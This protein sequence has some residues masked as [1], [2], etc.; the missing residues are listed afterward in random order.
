MRFYNHTMQEAWVLSQDVGDG[1]MSGKSSGMVVVLNG[2]SG[3]S[4]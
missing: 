1:G 2:L 4:L 3:A